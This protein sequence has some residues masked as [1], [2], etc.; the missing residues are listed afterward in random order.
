[1]TD[2]QVKS[3]GPQLKSEHDPKQILGRLIL[4]LQSKAMLPTLQ[5]C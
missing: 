3:N 4:A 1:M 5:D 2:L